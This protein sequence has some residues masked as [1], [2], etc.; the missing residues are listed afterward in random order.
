LSKE[1]V[2]QKK[3]SNKEFFLFFPFSPKNNP[4]DLLKEKYWLVVFHVFLNRS[5]LR[6]VFDNGSGA[7]IEGLSFVLAPVL[8]LLLLP[9]LLLCV[10]L[11]LL[12]SKIDCD[13]I[14]EALRLLGRPGASSFNSTC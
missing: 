5:D 2:P 10:F 3:L 11:L 1:K 7:A 9:L 13:A 8:L 6:I 4:R 12:C 14:S